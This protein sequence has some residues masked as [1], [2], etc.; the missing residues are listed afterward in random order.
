M[1][2]PDRF[3]AAASNSSQYNSIAIKVLPEIKEQ[4]SRDPLLF[5]VH[6]CFEVTPKCISFVLFAD[7]MPQENQTLPYSN[8]Y[9]LPT[10]FL[11]ECL[12]LENFQPSFL[13]R[14]AQIAMLVNCANHLP[15]YAY[16]CLIS[17]LQFRWLRR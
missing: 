12:V 3:P 5:F 6:F 7:L 10:V 15:N 14:Q 4:Y 11:D 16:D 17:T 8:F 13:V 2:Q 9:Y 1:G